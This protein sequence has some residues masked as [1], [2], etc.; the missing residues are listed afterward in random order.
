MCYSAQIWQEYQKYVRAFGATLDVAAFV[1]LFWSRVEDDRI[2]IPKALETAFAGTEGAPDARIPEFIADYRTQ[3]AQ[4]L[5]QELFAQRTRLT[6]A[7]RALQQKFTKS[8]SNSARIA[9]TKVKQLKVRI[10]DLHRTTLTGLDARIFPGYFALVMVIVD[11]HRVLRPMR[12]QCRP[13]GMPADSDKKFPGTYS[14]RRDNLE[15]FW[16]GQFGR[17][18]GLV[19]MNAFYEYVTR[20]DANGSEKIILEFRPQPQQDLLVA[21]LWSH[22]TGHGAPD[23]DS[24]AVITDE[25]PAEVAAAGHDRCLIAIKPEHIDTWLTPD[26]RNLAKF[27]AILDDRDRPHYEHRL[28]A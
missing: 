13:A 2:K 27:H 8:A 15:G 7:E 25:P 22:W 21:C 18:H 28:A 16:R 11:G 19:V 17:T 4:K 9:A 5:E 1:D 6:E 10:A 3:Q 14:A 26:P 23:L 12:F 24:F 20:A